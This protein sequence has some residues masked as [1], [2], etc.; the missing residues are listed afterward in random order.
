M[1]FEAHNWI[2][3]EDI[4]KHELILNREKTG[5]EWRFLKI[6]KKKKIVPTHQTRWRTYKTAQ[7]NFVTTR[8]MTDSKKFSKNEKHFSLT[9]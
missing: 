3:R 8:E 7:K 5:C 1:A 6:E 2:L 9:P 4:C